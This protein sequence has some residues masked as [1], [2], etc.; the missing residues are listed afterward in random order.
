MSS[1]LSHFADWSRGWKELRREP[2]DLRQVC[3]QVLDMWRERVPEEC[4][5]K[6][7]HEIFGY[8]HNH[9]RGEGRGEQKIE[10]VFLG[11]KG[12]SSKEHRLVKNSRLDPIIVKGVAHKMALATRRRGQVITDCLG[13]LYLRAERHPLA[14][15]VKIGA[16][17][18]W[19]AVVENLQQVKMHRSNVSN[20]KE[21]FNDRDIPALRDLKGAWGMVLAPTDYFQRKV[22]LWRKSLSLIDYLART[23]DARIMLVS[24]DNIIS[25]GELR[26]VG[27]HWP[28]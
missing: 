17:D 12:E 19:F 7:W 6:S 15:E 11:E 18:L 16:N 22:D 13:I 5:R 3:K 23:T 24:S 21:Y 9:K 20:V 10:G 14:V 28:Q 4:F 25:N 1:K 27:G 26:H 2:A 8:R